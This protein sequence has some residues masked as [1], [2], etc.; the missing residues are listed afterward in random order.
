[1]KGSCL[2]RREKKNIT[3][4][5]FQAHFRQLANKEDQ[6]VHQHLF[7]FRQY[8]RS[9]NLRWLEISRPAKRQEDINSKGGPEIN[10]IGLLRS[11]ANTKT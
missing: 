10:S 7:Q 6:G 11:Q 5:R 3:D 4:A 1:M 8:L 2:L 9:G